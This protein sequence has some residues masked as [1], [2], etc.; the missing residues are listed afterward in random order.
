MLNKR[1]I[2]SDAL[3]CGP[4][5]LMVLLVDWRQ[6]M[7]DAIPKGQQEGERNKEGK[8]VR[9]ISTSPIELQKL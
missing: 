7:D 8:K 3:R 4:N 5:A 2:S 1:Q 9:R 6:K